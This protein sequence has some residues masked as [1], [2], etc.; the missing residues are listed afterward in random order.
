MEKPW[1]L[2][3]RKIDLGCRLGSQG[4]RLGPQKSWRTL[5]WCFC[6]AGS[7]LGGLGYVISP[8]KTSLSL[9]IKCAKY[10]ALGAEDYWGTEG[11]IIVSYY[12]PGPIGAEH[13]ASVSWVLPFN[14]PAPCYD[15]LSFLLTQFTDKDTE[16][17]RGDQHNCEVTAGS[18]VQVNPEPIPT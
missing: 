3:L 11:L 7:S 15:S 9:S 5:G 13:G 17:R 8:I 12:E 2:G 16:V 18:P 14:L 4:P 10:R 1:G 6:S